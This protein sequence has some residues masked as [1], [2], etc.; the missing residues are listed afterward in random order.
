VD[1]LTSKNAAAR[2]GLNNVQKFHRLVAANNVKP[3]ASVDGVRGAKVWSRFDIDKL[4]EKVG[5]TI[6][7]EVAS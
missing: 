7:D 3:V 6:V 5:L 1:I 4:A 2:L